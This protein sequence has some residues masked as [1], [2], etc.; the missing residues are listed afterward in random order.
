[1]SKKVR[2]TKNYIILVLLIL[3]I[4][5]L[6][7][8]F[9]SINNQKIKYRIGKESCKNIEEIKV[10]NENI[11]AI[12]EKSIDLGYINNIELLNLY[13]NYSDIASNIIEL[14][15][16]YLFYEDNKYVF[17]FEKELDTDKNILN[18]VNNNIEDY[19]FSILN[20]DME[21][22]LVKLQLDNSVLNNF[23]GMKELS[24]KIDTYYINFYDTHLSDVEG[25]ERSKKIIK[26]YYWIDILEGLH[27]INE[28][29][30]DYDF[31]LNE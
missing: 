1:M 27:A 24:D 9:T 20:K 16:E 6:V 25:E 10:N 21:N 12:L 23:N 13:R 17:R 22:N 11:Q 19:L 2:T 3:S 26:E 31:N 14:W 8:V 4:S 15:D 30:K 29:Y 18:D 28:E 7:N 5:L